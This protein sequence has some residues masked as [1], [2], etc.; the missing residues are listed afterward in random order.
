MSGRAD[1]GGWRLRAL[2]WSVAFSAVGYLAVAI[3]SGWHDVVRAMYQVGATGLATALALSLLNYALRFARWRLYLGAMGHRLPA[4][5]NLRIYLSGFALTTTPGKAGELFRGVLLKP[6]GV[7]HSHSIAAFFSERLSDLLAVVLLALAALSLYPQARVPVAGGA[8][9]VLL[10]LLLLSHERLL[11]QLE[12]DIS[13]GGRVRRLLGYGVSALLQARRCHTPRLLLAASALALIGWS[14][15]AL[16]FHLILQWIGVEIGLAAAVGIFSIAIIA[17]ALSLSPG[18]LGS[19]EGVMA[20]LLLW[21]G[22]SGADAVAATVLIRLVTLWF[23]TA[24]GATLLVMQRI[25]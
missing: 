4:R 19:T 5:S 24:I 23:A 14:A 9:V 1:A 22:V 17:G 20:G 16:A 18:G 25:R 8:A 21:Q 6:L 2:V 10:G 11:R 12:V 7:P 13:G 3:W 15:E